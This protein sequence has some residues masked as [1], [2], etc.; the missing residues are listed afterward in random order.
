MSE[1]SGFGKLVKSDFL[2]GLVTALFAAVFMTLAGF[3][4]QPDF[5]L[6]T[7]DWGA[8]LGMAMNAGFAA[9]V[10]YLGKN[11][12]TDSKGEVNLGVTKIK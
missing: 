2:K 3:V 11:L 5:N 10:G 7:A 8:I 12:L 9:L 4:Q 1:V 6:F